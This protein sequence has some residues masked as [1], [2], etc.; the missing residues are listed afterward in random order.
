MLRT[1]YL[2]ILTAVGVGCS[3]MNVQ[4]PTAAIT[5]MSVQDVNAS[6]FTMNFGVDLKNPNTM[7][8]PLTAADYKLG[9]SGVKVVEGKAKPEGSIPAGGSRHVTLPVT[10]T[11]ENLLAAEKAIMKSGGNVPY[12]LDGGLSLN[13]G[14]PM[15]GNLRVPLEYQGTLPLGEILNNPRAIMQSPAA[16][17]LAK[18]LIGG[19]FGR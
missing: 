12:S 4:T 2:I 8:L 10:L 16:Q 11:Y 5:G 9:L 18:Q 14:V 1:T 3:A 13:S 19:L 15:L 17:K 6:G 7:A